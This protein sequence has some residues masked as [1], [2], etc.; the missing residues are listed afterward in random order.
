MVFEKLR[1]PIPEGA[2]PEETLA[3]RILEAQRTG[4]H[5]PEEEAR[6]IINYLRE[7]VRATPLE[8]ATYEETPEEI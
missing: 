8:T 6:R 1:I 2:R 5:V 7:R 3:Q 4:R